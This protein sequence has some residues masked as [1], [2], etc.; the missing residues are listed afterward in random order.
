MTV[1][2]FFSFVYFIK[3]RKQRESLQLSFYN[4]AVPLV[5][6]QYYHSVIILMIQLFIIFIY[7]KYGYCKHN[8]MCDL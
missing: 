2:F 3:S 8:M 4:G 5:Y 6:L 7:L 1:K